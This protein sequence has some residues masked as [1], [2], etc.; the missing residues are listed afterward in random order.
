MITKAVVK[1][2]DYGGNKCLVRIPLFETAS[3][4]AEVEVH[5]LINN[6]PGIFN[7]LY[8]GDIVF[9]GFE[10]NALEKPIILGKLY[11]GANFESNA[12]GGN[13]NFNHL[14]V[15][16]SAAIPSS[17]LFVYP[18]EI[19]ST[20]A[21]YNTPKLLADRIMEIRDWLNL[22][23][24]HHELD[25]EKIRLAMQPWNLEID[26]GDL[27]LTSNSSMI[28]NN[29]PIYHNVKLVVKTPLTLDNQ[30]PLNY[31]L[32]VSPN[33]DILEQVETDLS[34]NTI[35]KSKYKY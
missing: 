31:P 24:E 13:G 9:I 20:Y 16:T 19:A 4:D 26:D 27:D 35:K 1:N 18:K 32:K 2:V 8:P 25:M 12:L 14:K 5:A 34:V 23:S 3:S 30:T 10:E 29:N 6:P 33:K 17:T 28:S 15:F 21:D 22:L 7:N 11:R